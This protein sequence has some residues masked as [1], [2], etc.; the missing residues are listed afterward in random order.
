MVED[1]LIPALHYFDI[2]FYAYNPVRRIT[3]LYYPN[4]FGWFLSTPAI[5]EQHW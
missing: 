3:K 1:E 4:L 5:L 2:R